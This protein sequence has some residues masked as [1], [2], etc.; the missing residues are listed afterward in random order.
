VERV[1]PDR[2][3]APLLAALAGQV[4]DEGP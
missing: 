2:L 1:T 3:R 4:H